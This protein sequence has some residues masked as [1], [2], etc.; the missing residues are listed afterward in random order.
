MEWI[1]ITPRSQPEEGKR[2]RVRIEETHMDQ[3]FY[4]EAIALRTAF[5][6]ELPEGRILL[7]GHERITHFSPLSSDGQ[8]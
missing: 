2:Y 4:S 1:E 6:W 8:T 3:T 5:G 7:P